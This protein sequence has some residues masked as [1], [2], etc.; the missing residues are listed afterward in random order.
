MERIDKISIEE[1][2]DEGQGCFIIDTPS[3]KYYFQKESGGFSS[4]HDREGIDWINF[5]ATSYG[6]PGDA[7]GIFR[8]LP[9]MVWPDNIGHPGHKKMKSALKGANQVHCISSNKLWEW[10]CTFYEDRARLDV[11]KTA[12]GRQYWFLY[13]GTQGGRF[14]PFN[15]FWGTEKHGRRHDT[16]ICH[17]GNPPPYHDYWKIVYFGFKDIPRVFY[18]VI[19]SEQAPYNL[20]SYMGS[21]SQDLKAPDGMTVFG[22]GRGP[23]PKALLEGPASFTMGFLETT[24]HDEIIKY[25]QEEVL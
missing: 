21:T 6:I 5:K 13:E 10:Q 23:G 17:Q 22:F 16:P 15:S 19:H 9:N 20:Y 8:G 24:D 18:T 11:T 25:L 7:G 2:V 3:S 4:I 12:P 1:G 14:D